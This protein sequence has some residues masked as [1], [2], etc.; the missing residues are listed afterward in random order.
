M[1]RAR[2]CSWFGPVV[3][4]PGARNDAKTGEWW[5]ANG[6]PAEHHTRTQKYHMSNYSGIS[7]MG[8][9]YVRTNIHLDGLT[10]AVHGWLWYHATIFVAAVVVHL[11]CL[12]GTI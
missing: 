1:G 7:S 3:Q 5:L 4:S 9:T 11:S 8:L 2:G 12:G 10:H 6:I